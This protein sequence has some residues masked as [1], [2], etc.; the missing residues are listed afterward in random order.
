MGLLLFCPG[1]GYLSIKYKNLADLSPSFNH[2][3]TKE[4]A[5]LFILH[6]YIF[7]CRKSSLP[8]KF[9]LILFNR[10]TH[11][12]VRLSAA[13]FACLLMLP[14]RLNGWGFFAH[15]R[16]NRLAVFSLP[17]EMM[18]FYK[19]HL[20]FITAHATDPDKRRYV[21]A[22][23]GPR[24]YIDV[25]HYGPPPFDSLPRS[26]EAAAARY[27]ADT[28]LQHG[29]LPWHIPRMLH[30][31]TNAFREKDAARILQLSA[32]LG[33]YVADAHVPLHASTNHNGQLSGQHGIHALWESRIPELIADKEFNYWSGR[34]VYISDVAA[35]AW[36]VVISSAVAA[37]T[38]L[39]LEK[40]LSRRFPPAQRY[41]WEK[42]NGVLTRNYSAAYSLAYHRLM[43]K[44][45]ERRMRSAI[46][47]V[48][49]CWYTAWV[50]AG[51]PPLREL[52][53]KKFSHEQL[54]QFRELER[55][56]QKG[57]QPG[58]EHEN[59]R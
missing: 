7:S 37:D 39:R 26:W 10:L 59:D 24:H 33:H 25:D 1:W 8:V 48:A 41:A 3:L 44:M 21:V 32:E 46:A 53:G 45:V 2:I 43:D 13:I 17:P 34:A 11:M 36:E 5:V 50:D 23:E 16:I 4:T 52:A 14:V 29:I 19:P 40:E 58:R 55:T 22:E 9:S 38:V 42:R 30:R 6:F 57:R 47:A 31:L 49:S 51:Q 27:T 56:W 35:F 15:R 28:L 54:R 12:C 20:E 18:I